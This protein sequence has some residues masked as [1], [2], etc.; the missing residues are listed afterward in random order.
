MVI[1]RRPPQEAEAWHYAPCYK[2]RLH[3]HMKQC[4]LRRTDNVSAPA[5]S[6][7]E[8]LLLVETNLPENDQLTTKLDS[9]ID[10]MRDTKENEGIT[11]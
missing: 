10:G 9:L 5:D 1:A 7:Q 3:L 8:G 6:F 4:P 11:D 2:D